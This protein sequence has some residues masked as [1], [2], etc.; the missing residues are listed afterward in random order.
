MGRIRN[1]SLSPSSVLPLV[2]CREELNFYSSQQRSCCFGLYTYEAWVNPEQPAGCLQLLL[3]QLSTLL[4]QCRHCYLL[5]Q[6][7]PQFFSSNWASSCSS[8]LTAPQDSWH[9]PCAT[10]TGSP[11]GFVDFEGDKHC[12]KIPKRFLRNLEAVGSRKMALFSDALAIENT[13]KY[14]FPSRFL[15]TSTSSPKLSKYFLLSE[16]CQRCEGIS[17]RVKHARWT[18]GFYLLQKMFENQR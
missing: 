4:A 3:V 7:Q 17:P 12:E 16:F 5:R 11:L 10:H 1:T 8:A 9:A 6:E 2:R 18:E 13:L 15:L 14:Y